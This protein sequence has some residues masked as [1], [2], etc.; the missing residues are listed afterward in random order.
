[1]SERNILERTKDLHEQYVAE[2]LALI[3]PITE[4]YAIPVNI[5]FNRE[6][7]S[8]LEQLS[9]NQIRFETIVERLTNGEA[10]TVRLGFTIPGLEQVTGTVALR[11]KE[12][13]VTAE[14]DERIQQ[15]LNRS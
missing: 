11:Y 15:L 14:Y 6:G 12:G 3:Q 7:K 1:M 5:S 8:K 13:E 4:R 2:I 9:E 10:D